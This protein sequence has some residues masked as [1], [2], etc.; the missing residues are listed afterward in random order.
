MKIIADRSL[1]QG[2]GQCIEAAPDVFDL[3]DEA[4]VVVLDGE[5]DE[6]NRRAVEEA[7]DRCP[8][9]ALRIED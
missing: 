7:V 5:P 6:A 4:L 3:D 8:V 9:D 1:C 2:H